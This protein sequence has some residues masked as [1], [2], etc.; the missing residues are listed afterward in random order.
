MPNQ[1]T[2]HF[3]YWDE[4][5]GLL[6]SDGDG[7]FPSQIWGFENFSNPDRREES[8]DNSGS[9]FGFVQTGAAVVSD[10]TIEWRLISEQWFA[11]PS[12]FEITLDSRSRVVVSQRIGFHGIYAMGG[13]VEKFGRLRYIDGCSDTILCAPL[14]LGDPC[15][16]LLHFPENI[17]Q[18][19]HTHPSTRAGIVARGKGL[20]ITPL[21]ETALHPGRIFYIPKD[22]IHKFKT[23]SGVTMDVIAYHP[24]SDWG[25]THEEHPM[26]NRTL[27]DGRKI[28]N[29]D[30]IHKAREIVDS[31]LE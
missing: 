21:G 29:T 20:C 5:W 13:P 4:Y 11:L 23:V 25:P 15:L 7:R 8:V 9:T 2:E 22:G 6:L 16:N 17:D 14:L 12:G 30:E 3:G 31:T 24:D 10:G 26:V 18:T 19:Q 1:Q 27:V 28:D